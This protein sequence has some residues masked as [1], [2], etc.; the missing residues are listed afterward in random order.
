[1]WRDKEKGKQMFR[2]WK[3]KAKPKREKIYYSLIYVASLSRLKPADP[4]SELWLVFSCRVKIYL[5]LSGSIIEWI[6]INPTFKM[7]SQ[8][9]RR[10]IRMDSF[11]TFPRKEKVAMAKVVQ[12]C[13]AFTKRLGSRPILFLLSLN[14]TQECVCEWCPNFELCKVSTIPIVFGSS[15]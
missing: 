13:W 9:T 12:D 11:A 1:M 15:T 8:S 4:A 6:I 3:A 5:K 2:F 14:V 10:T 7:F